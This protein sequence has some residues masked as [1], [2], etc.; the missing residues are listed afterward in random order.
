MVVYFISIPALVLLLTLLAFVDF[1]LLRLNRAGILP[2]HRGADNRPVSSTGFEV[3]HGVLDPG[4]AHELNQRQTALVLREDEE[5]AAPGRGPID[6]DSGH[7]A[8]RRS[9]GAEAVR[10]SEGRG[11]AG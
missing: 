4:K 10:G 6:L 7:V 9:E 8:I 5:D 2:W 11:A 3:L 1:V